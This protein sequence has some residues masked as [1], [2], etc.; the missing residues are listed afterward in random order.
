MLM[1]RCKLGC[2]L[3]ELKDP[4]PYTEPAECSSSMQSSSTCRACKSKVA[5]VG[6]DDRALYCPGKAGTY[7]PKCGEATDSPTPLLWMSLGR[8]LWYYQ[9]GDPYWGSDG[10]NIG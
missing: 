7:A 9:H 5:G 8:S 6:I 10:D 2:G 1:Q 3:C 4:C